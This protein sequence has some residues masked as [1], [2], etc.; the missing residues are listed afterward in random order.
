MLNFKYKAILFDVDGT[1]IQN[2][3]NSSPSQAVCDVIANA[4]DNIPIGIAT[5]R[6]LPLLNE[7]FGTLKLSAPCVINGGAQIIDSQTY[8]NLSDQPINIVDVLS[9]IKLVIPYQLPIYIN[10]N[11]LE[12]QYSITYIPHKP[13][14]IYLEE[15]EPIVA[16]E[17]VNK[18]KIFKNVNV[19]KII[20]HN[21]D[22]MS[23]GITHILATKEHGV[24]KVAEF[25]KTSPEY[26]VGV[27]DGYNDISLLQSC[28]YKIAMGN[29][30]DEVKAIADYIAPSVEED[31]VVDILKKFDNGDL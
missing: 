24:K 25:L 1:L 12:I 9:I 31:G 28:G 3:K 15:L 5:A 6:S 7:I 23:L 14:F 17:L 16:D 13:Y 29:A 22:K 20:P 4:K 21:L 10:E 18:F 27:G 8:K 30:I 19:H 11:G 2:H 26:I